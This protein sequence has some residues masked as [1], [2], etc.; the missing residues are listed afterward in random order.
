MDG[1]GE[2]EVGNMT[3]GTKVKGGRSDTYPLVTR[4]LGGFR[5]SLPSLF[6]CAVH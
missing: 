2:D 3:T 1:M 4:C 6:P 5:L